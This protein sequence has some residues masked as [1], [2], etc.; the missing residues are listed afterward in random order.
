MLQGVFP[1]LLIL[2]GLY[3]LLRFFSGL[4]RASAANNVVAAIA[5]FATLSEEDQ[6]RVADRTEVI[7]RSSN[8]PAG[9]P[10]TF[11]TEVSKWG[12]Y[13]LAMRE[14][15]IAPVCLTP[16]WAVI[17][18]P[19]TAILVTDSMLDTSLKLAQKAGYSVTLSREPG[20]FEQLQRK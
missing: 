19:F 1:V 18:N 8:W 20:L 5:T 4:K 6:I 15:G 7:I 12:W 11:P 9:K 16:S 14:L 17:R 2:S 10:V 13:A 3:L